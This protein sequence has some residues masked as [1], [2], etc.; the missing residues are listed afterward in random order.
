MFDYWL[1]LYFQ[2][3]SLSHIYGG[4]SSWS[5][6]TLVYKQG[7]IFIT[8]SKQF[9]VDFTVPSK[10]QVRKNS[11]VARKKAAHDSC[12]RDDTWK[13]YLT[14]PPS[15]EWFLVV[16]KKTSGNKMQFCVLSPYPPPVF[17]KVTLPETKIATE[18]RPSQK[19]IH[20][21]TIHFQ[22]QDVSFRGMMMVCFS[23]SP[24]SSFFVFFQSSFFFGDF[25]TH[26]RHS[27][28][29]TLWSV[30]IWLATCLMEVL[31]Q[32]CAAF[33]QKKASGRTRALWFHSGLEKALAFFE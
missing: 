6:P 17:Q 29:F 26:L 4:D 10:K 2:V 33:K 21:P 18:N 22:V 31:R 24:L 20:L 19:E 3:F 12:G 13:P 27:H 9:V 16:K 7:V 28:W 11:S 30:A 23:F 5:T 15:L 25:W 14:T 8:N 32:H 1:L